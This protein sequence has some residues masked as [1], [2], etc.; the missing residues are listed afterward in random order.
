M[1]LHAYEES[2]TSVRINRRRWERFGPTT[3]LLLSTPDRLVTELSVPESAVVAVFSGGP[4]L[5]ASPFSERLLTRQPLPTWHHAP[6]VLREHCRKA[7]EYCDRK[8][9]DIAKLAIQFCLQ[10]PDITTTVAGTA[11]PMN[12]ANILK[13]IEQPLD[14]HLLAEVQR[15]LEPDVVTYEDASGNTVTALTLIPFRAPLSRAQR[16]WHAAMA[17]KYYLAADRPWLPVAPDP[18]APE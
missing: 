15:I 16:S 1:R 13:W 4:D 11:N 2:P 5:F 18:P 10:N 14:R 7:V 8:G 9:V 3:E 12:M 17:R 6:A